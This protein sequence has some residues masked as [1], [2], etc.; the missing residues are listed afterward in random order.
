MATA[1]KI[2]ESLGGIAVVARE[3]SLAM[4]TVQGWKDAN[5]VP[6]WRR[7]SLL[8]LAMARG[9]RLSTADFPSTDE[10]LPRAKSY[11]GG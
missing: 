4:T 6:E 8:A 7:P 11:R 1:Q 3:L 10:R 5:F 2:L 9:V